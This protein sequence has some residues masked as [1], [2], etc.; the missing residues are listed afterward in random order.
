MIYIGA[1]VQEFFFFFSATSRV[2]DV[3]PMELDAS[4]MFH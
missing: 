4:K 1:I 2:S 3:L